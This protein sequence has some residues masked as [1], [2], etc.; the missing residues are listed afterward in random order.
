MIVTAK[1]PWCLR[2]RAV[3]VHEGGE[4]ECC[5]CFNYGPFYDGFEIG[6]HPSLYEPWPATELDRQRN[7]NY[8]RLLLDA[9]YTVQELMK[10]R[11]IS[12]KRVYALASTAV[13]SERWRQDSGFSWSSMPDRQRVRYLC[14]WERA[15][16]YLREWDV[17][18]PTSLAID[19][20]FNLDD[21]ELYAYAIFWTDAWKGR[22]I[23]ET[24]ATR[25]VA[26]SAGHQALV[27]ALGIWDDWWE[28]RFILDLWEAPDAEIAVT[29]SEHTARARN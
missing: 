18:I 29:I 27:Y 15:G 12:A 24:V 2:R 4:L 1:C 14:Q 19:W 9:R 17:E 22:G 3:R 20:L 5:H 11:G 25:R 16:N 21:D 23:A 8:R 6:E 28:R 10:A 13:A 7:L 26:E